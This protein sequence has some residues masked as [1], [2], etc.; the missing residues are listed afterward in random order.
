M[1]VTAR[2]AWSLGLIILM[3]V[4]LAASAE[5]QV[6]P[7]AA[8]QKRVLVLHLTPPNSLVSRAADDTYRQRL[9]AAFPGALD[10]YADYVDIYRFSDPGYRD[11]LR[12]Y[13]RDRYTPIGLNL[14]ITP[15]T[16]QLRMIRDEED[17]LFP[18]VPIVFHAGVGERG[19][20]GSTGVVSRVDF[21]PIME[22]ALQLH[23]RTRRVVVIAGTSGIDTEYANLSRK[24]FQRF[25]DRVTF[26][27]LVGRPIAEMEQTVSRLP[28][29]TIVCFILYSRNVAGELWL[30]YDALKRIT[31]AA[32]V[33]VYGIHEQMFGAGIVGGRLFSTQATVEA[34]ADLAI[35]ILR[36]EAP[37]AIPVTEITPYITAFDW[38]QLSR[39]GISERALPPGSAVMFRPPSALQRYRIPLLALATIGAIATAAV[40]ERR[41]RRAEASSRSYLDAVATIDR[42]ATVTHFSASLAHEL[43][44]PLAAIGSNVDAMRRLLD[45]G[46]LDPET[47]RE[48]LSDIKS[49]NRRAAHLIERI[50]SFVRH[51]ER[52]EVPIDVHDLLRETMSMVEPTAKSAGVS[53]DITIASDPA[54]VSGDPIHLQQVFLNLLGNAIDAVSGLDV[55]RRRI[56]VHTCVASDRV[57][58][59]VRDCGV[60]FDAAI[61]TNAFQPF[62]TTKADGM[63]MGLFIVRNIV[64]AHHGKVFAANDPEGGAVV[65]V[66]LPRVND[67]T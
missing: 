18:H 8:T 36:G 37:A 10:Y 55:S 12:Q 59:V 26:E 56:R 1:R 15:N 5:A 65:H 67:P 4:C 63:G 30:P 39:W 38:R 14:V 3:G 51:H 53:I 35:R 42:R 45:A 54:T 41:R 61:L 27:Y 50:R 33:P 24:Q 44:Q 57:E 52:E 62:V 20:A 58:I 19:D 28:S 34:T 40:F 49:S 66:R 6:P 32:N 46:K 23:P 60:G 47:L 29:D 17:G 21:A 25:A 43:R 7:T 64:D 13:L 22:T 16:V 11:T 9:G 31:A 2:L 48:I